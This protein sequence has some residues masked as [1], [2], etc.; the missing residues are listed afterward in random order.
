VKYKVLVPIRFHYVDYKPG[1]EIEMN[2]TEA[3][4]LLKG[5]AIELIVKPFS[6]QFEKTALHTNNQEQ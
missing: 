6:K 5:E 1:D 3:V 2:D 4:N